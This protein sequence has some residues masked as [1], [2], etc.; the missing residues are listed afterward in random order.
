MVDIRLEDVDL[1]ATMVP[2][3]GIDVEIE[4]VGKIVINVPVSLFLAIGQAY[5]FLTCKAIFLQSSDIGTKVKLLEF[6]QSPPLHE[7]CHFKV[8]AKPERFRVV[9]EVI[10]SNRD[11]DL[12]LL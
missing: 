1:N 7:G 3:G 5:C 10:V 9:P 6:H 4:G 11:G 2:Q 8:I 12:L